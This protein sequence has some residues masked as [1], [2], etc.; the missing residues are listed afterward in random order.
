MT[1]A[2]AKV[3]M[4]AMKK[5]NIAIIKAMAQRANMSR[6]KLVSQAKKISRATPKTKKMTAREKMLRSRKGQDA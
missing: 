4:S 5:N 6:G 1:S 3:V 2:V